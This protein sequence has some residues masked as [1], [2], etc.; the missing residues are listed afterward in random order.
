MRILFFC[1]AHNSL[2]QRLFLELTRKHTVTVEYALSEAAMI[3]AAEL[4]KPHLIICPFLTTRVPHKVHDAFLTLIVHPGPPGDAG[5]SALDWLLMGDDGRE[6]DSSKLL[7]QDGFNPNGRSHWG[8]TVLQA[9]E[10]FDAGQIWAFEQFS[11]DI[12]EPGLTKSSLY[13]GLVTQA[14]VSASLAAIERIE[15]AAAA[16]ASAAGVPL[17]PP[18][19]PGH[20]SAAVCSKLNSGLIAHKAFSE[21]SVSSAQPFQGGKTHR[22]PLLRAAERDFDPSRHTAAEISRRIRSGDSQPGCLSTVFGPKLYLYGGI[23]D[24]TVKLGDAAP[25]DILA[26]RHEAVCISTCDG[27][28]VWITH[29]RRVKRSEDPALWP[30]VPAAPALLEMGCID[31]SAVYASLSAS[32]EWT[33]VAA[34][35]LQDIW[36]DMVAD[37]KKRLA[38][39]YFDFYNGAM[40]TTQCRKLV[41][42]L[43]HILSTAEDAEDHRPLA[44]VI[45]MGGHSYFSNG[46]HLNVIEAA[47][48][49]ALESWYN[50]NAINDVVETI[51]R[52]FPARGIRTVAAVRGNCAAGGVALATA[53]D[54]VIAGEHVVLNPAYRALGL[55]GSEFHSLTYPGRC[56]ESEATAA[57]RLMTPLSAEDASKKGFVDYVLPGSG[58]VLEAAVRDRVEVLFSA[59]TALSKDEV[60]PQWKMTLDLS[61][62]A[63]ARARAAELAQMAMDFWSPRSERY[64]RR[65]RDFV[66]KAK[67]TS[68]PLRFA[69]HRRGP[70]MLDEEEH[71][72]FDSIEWFVQKSRHEFRQDMAKKMTLLITNF[73]QSDCEVTSPYKLGFGQAI[74]G[75]TGIKDGIKAKPASKA[76]DVVFSCY[77]SS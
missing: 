23:I 74:S 62:A 17:S 20:V 59:S 8:V 1:T 35:T 63:L 39:V 75:N 24:D 22:R 9:N 7:L 64:H 2:S 36:I 43:Q 54:I 38:Y 66:R 72:R 76:S 51:L 45:L 69:V 55:H 44:A 70:G 21:L 58:V 27:K 41:T 6:A 26:I 47:A 68:T 71:D 18:G 34:N 61:P 46:I 13:R 16:A 14:A 15:Y 42:A 5:P 11:I 67:A 40:S 33:K 31:Q 60:A 77:Y 29:I 65:R 57:V 19:S 56:G 4:A 30:K 50:I 32:D 28:G 37:E 12:N 49:P 53:C 52:D 3:E 10:D 73:S 25:G 48:D